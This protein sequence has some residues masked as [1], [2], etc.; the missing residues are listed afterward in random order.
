MQFFRNMKIGARLTL[1][2]LLVVLLTIAVGL[3]GIRN[4]SEVSGLSDLMYERDLTGID[5]VHSA[6][7]SLIVAGRALRG[8]L[9]AT[10]VEAQ[11]GRA[12]V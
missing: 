3:L 12:H 10:T 1:G 2:F 8:S 5:A 6:N 4:L 11:I 7:Y 9:L